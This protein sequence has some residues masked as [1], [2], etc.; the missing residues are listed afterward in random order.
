MRADYLE[1][2]A[3]TH[4]VIDGTVFRMRDRHVVGRML[5]GKSHATKVKADTDKKP[6]ERT[7]NAR[8]HPDA[9]GRQPRV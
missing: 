9:G 5:S 7:R 2:G 8:R 3:G 4:H 6:G 1:T